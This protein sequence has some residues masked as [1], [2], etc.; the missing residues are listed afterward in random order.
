MSTGIPQTDKSLLRDSDLGA[1]NDKNVCFSFC[2][3]V[4]GVLIP[5]HHTLTFCRM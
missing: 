2:V 1:G 5:T 3:F 4:S